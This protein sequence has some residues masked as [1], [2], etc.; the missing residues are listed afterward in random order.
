MKW[1]GILLL[2]S[3]LG[4]PMAAQE[5][6]TATYAPVD[7]KAVVAARKFY[8]GSLD[9]Y[10]QASTLGA[11]SMSGYSSTTFGGTVTAVTACF[12]NES[13]FS[14][15]FSATVYVLQRG[16]TIQSIAFARGFP[17]ERYTCHTVTGF[18]AFLLP[19]EF[20]I[21]VAYD[22][23]RNENFWAG[24]SATDSGTVFDVEI[25]GK[26]PP[27]GTGPQGPVRMNGVGLG[28]SITE[29]DQPPAPEACNADG[30]TLCLNQGRFKVEGM[31]EAGGQ[32]AIPIQMVKLT[33]ESGYL[34]FFSATNVEAFVKVLNGC[35]LNK[36]YW[37]FVGGLTDVRVT[38]TVTDTVTRETKT[39]T[40]PS[41]TLFK[42]V[43]D[44][45]AM[46]V[47]P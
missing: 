2:S 46:D 3:S 38:I 17:P 12:F 27:Y 6:P 43:A 22:R 21:S 31:F 44:T 42:P 40:N 24:L 14:R 30:D 39:Y 32:P 33:D 28:Y 45:S 10:W 16:K 1:V 18:N 5:Y 47:C 11:L 35:G 25:G 34:W 15:E 41:G 4:M 20:E 13:A 36:H 7:G 8:S 37:V 23:S 9:W 26:R 19:G 29:F